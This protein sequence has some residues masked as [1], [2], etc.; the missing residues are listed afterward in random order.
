MRQ[1]PDQIRSVY[2]YTKGDRSVG[3]KGDGA[4]L[5]AEGDF[6]IDLTLIQDDQREDV[7]K[8]FADKLIEAYSL[9]WNEQVYVMF[10]FQCMDEPEQGVLTQGV[11]YV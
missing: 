9:I 2:V 10:D 3:F 8:A 5:T 4:V 11:K 7:L 1:L 6:M